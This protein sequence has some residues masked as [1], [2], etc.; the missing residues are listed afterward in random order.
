[1][2]AQVFNSD[3]N[4]LFGRIMFPWTYLFQEKEGPELNVDRVSLS[5]TSLLHARVQGPLLGSQQTV[6]NMIEA[7]L[8][9][10]EL[11]VEWRRQKKIVEKSKKQNK[12]IRQRNNCSL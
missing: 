11:I 5:N 6:V 10:M 9:F 8:A 12:A 3:V 1:M 4:H 2:P 7:V